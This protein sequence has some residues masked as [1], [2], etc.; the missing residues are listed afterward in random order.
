MTGFIWEVSGNAGLSTAW[1][2]LV[3]S[4]DPIEAVREATK[5]H[6]WN[7]TVGVTVKGVEALFPTPNPDRKEAGE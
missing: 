3:V 5:R 1:T 4:E 6:A 2:V 7:L